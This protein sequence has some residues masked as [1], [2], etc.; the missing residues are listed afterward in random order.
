[1]HLKK[2]EIYVNENKKQT[3]LSISRLFAIYEQIMLFD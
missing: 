2:K 3:E 1:M